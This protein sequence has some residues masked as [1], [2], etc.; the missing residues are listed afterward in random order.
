MSKFDELRAATGRAQVASKRA[1]KSLEQYLRDEQEFRA[2]VSA[3]TAAIDALKTSAD[4]DG[5][6][7]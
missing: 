3:I 6:E 7:S 4:G 2:A 1:S 5:D